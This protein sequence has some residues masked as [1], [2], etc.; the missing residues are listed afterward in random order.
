MINQVLL[1]GRVVEIYNESID[2]EVDGVKFPVHICDV[3]NIENLLLNNIVAIKGYI[4]TNNTGEI[5]VVYDTMII[6]DARGK[7]ND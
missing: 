6:L 5:F 7:K 1:R 3:T 4:Q 2:I